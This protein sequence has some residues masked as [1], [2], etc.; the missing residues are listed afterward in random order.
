[1]SFSWFSCF[2]SVAEPSAVS[3]MISYFTPGQAEITRSMAYYNASLV[4]LIYIVSAVY[5]HNYFL[6]IEQLA[7]EIKTSFSSLIYRKALKLSPLALSE[8]SLGNIVTVITKDVQTFEK[9]IWIFNESIVTLVQTAVLSYLLYLRIG[10]VSLV[11][12]GVL[13]SIMPIQCKL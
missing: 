10:A 3:N 9:A 1:M 6:C 11:G 2:S 13:L 12:V 4:L 5:R 7:V 8:I